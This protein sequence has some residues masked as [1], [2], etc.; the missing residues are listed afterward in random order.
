M[1]VWDRR[2]GAPR[3]LY[4]AGRGAAEPMGSVNT[5]NVM[6]AAV[7][8]SFEILNRMHSS[9]RNRCPRP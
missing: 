8:A 6:N 5:F 9:H 4:A 2:M 1:V 3:H 7:C